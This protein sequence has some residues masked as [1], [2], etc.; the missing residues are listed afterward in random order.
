MDG[1]FQHIKT[2]TSGLIKGE[3]E[4][5]LDKTKGKKVKPMKK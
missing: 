3:P 2:S 4:F 5:T 1:K